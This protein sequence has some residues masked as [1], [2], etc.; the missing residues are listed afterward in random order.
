MADFTITGIAELKAKLKKNIELSEV[1]KVVKENSS[2]LHNALAKNASTDTFNKGYS[3]GNLRDD[4]SS[5]MPTISDGGLT[6]KQG[7]NV[8]YAGYLIKGTR[9]MEPEDWFTGP[10]NEW[11]KKFNNDMKKLTK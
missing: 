7:T 10:W 9:F 1:K 11:S 3:T 2:Q 5:N 6:A 4:L 8:E